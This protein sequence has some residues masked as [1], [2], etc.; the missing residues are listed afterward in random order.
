MKFSLMELCSFIVA[1]DLFHNVAF[2][3]YQRKE[4]D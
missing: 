3:C 4:T 1:E 2:D